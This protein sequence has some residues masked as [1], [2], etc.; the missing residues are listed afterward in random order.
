[1]MTVFFGVRIAQK[2][3][4]VLSE[5]EGKA[6]DILYNDLEINVNSPTVTFLIPL[7]SIGKSTKALTVSKHFPTTHINVPHPKYKERGVKSRLEIPSRRAAACMD[8]SV[9]WQVAGL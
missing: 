4:E 3:R 2:A 7:R 8:S 9:T 5:E 6:A 1:M